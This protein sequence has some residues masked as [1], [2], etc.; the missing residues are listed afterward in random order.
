MGIS[1]TSEKRK[2][3]L[4]VLVIF[5]IGAVVGVALLQGYLAISSPADRRLTLTETYYDSIN[6]TMTPDCGSVNDLTPI[7]FSNPDLVKQGTED[8]WTV[9]MVTWTKYNSSYP[10]GKNVSTWWGDTWLTVAPELQRF[11]LNKVDHDA[12]LTLRAAQLLGMPP[13]NYNLY[14]VEM[15]VHPADLFRPSADNEV[16]D[17][18]ASLTMPKNINA[19]YKQWFDG[20]TISS[21]YPKTF[22]W[23]RLGYTYDWG[24]SVTHEG[25]SE[26][27]LKKN[28]TVT[29]SSVHPTAEYLNVW[30][31]AC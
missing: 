30:G 10:V 22:P 15:Y 23:T 19:T 9:L 13:A 1:I 17:T 27:V 31:P 6:R 28:S 18:S 3:L 29:V 8:N 11:F 5:M 25:L 24:N 21:Y 12:N 2:R 14:F 4:T 7:I 20:N 16:N 26:F